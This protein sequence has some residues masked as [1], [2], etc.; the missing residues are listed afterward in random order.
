M[1]GTKDANRGGAEMERMRDPGFRSI[2]LSTIVSLVALIGS[3]AS[4]SAGLGS[5][6]IIFSVILVL[7]IA[8]LTFFIFWPVMIPN[9]RGVSLLT[10]IGQAGL[11]DIEDR[12]YEEKP[13]PP[14]EYYRLAKHEI[15]LTGITLITTFRLHR[16]LLLERLKANIEIYVLLIDPLNSP[17]VHRINENEDRRDKTDI[18]HEIRDALSIMNSAG[19]LEYYN[20]HMFH[21]R[22]LQEKPPFIGVMIDGDIA[23][24]SPWAHDAQIRVQPL[25]MYKSVHKGTILQFKHEKKERSSRLGGFAFFAADLREQW[26]RA[27]ENESYL[28]HPESIV[29]TAGQ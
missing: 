21:V 14:A 4:I 17:E 11:V 6:G 15:A 25:R 28:E 19:F 9:W 24:V 29:W 5:I 1:Y 3:I 10:G 20:K 7:V 13:L 2:V 12:D 16:E 22:F 26:S 8:S 23:R 18:R 27:K